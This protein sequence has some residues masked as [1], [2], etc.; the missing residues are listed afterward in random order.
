MVSALGKGKQ[1]GHQY[2]T[3]LL[4]AQ[5]GADA[6]LIARQVESKYPK[7]AALFPDQAVSISAGLDGIGVVAKE[8]EVIPQQ[9]FEKNNCL[10]VVLLL[11]LLR[12]ARLD[13]GNRHPDPLAHRL[14][15]T[16]D[17]AYI[18]QHFLQGL[19]NVSQ[20]LMTGVAINLDG[21][22]RL[23]PRRSIDVTWRGNLQQVVGTASLCR[24][25]GIVNRV[26]GQASPVEF[27]AHRIDKERHIF[28]QHSHERMRGLPAMLG[29][30]R[31]EDAHLG[32]D[33]IK[34][35]NKVPYRQSGTIK[36]IQASIDEVFQR[37]HGI[38]MP[39]KSLYFR[40]P[41]LLKSTLQA[42]TQLLEYFLPPRFVRLVLH[43]T[44][45]LPWAVLGRG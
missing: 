35:L 2:E 10:L 20:H 5:L 17:N 21:K 29:E 3:T 24:Q 9:P 7:L 27:N 43:P 44:P 1:L 26:N 22:Q 32:R 12:A 36:I 19:L 15:I 45:R 14:V 34:V 11:D 6:L 40:S 33:R 38:K 28:V 41:G 25:D 16:H 23:P 13:L 37:D 39:G 8:G 42:F 31:I 18:A 4:D 30:V